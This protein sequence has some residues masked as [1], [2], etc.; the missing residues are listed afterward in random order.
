M[1]RPA[2]RLAL[3]LTLLGAPLGAQGRARNEAPP[4]VLHQLDAAAQGLARRV[5]PAIVQVVVTALASGDSPHQG[6]RS[7]GSG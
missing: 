2:V 1:T 3:C 7:N 6:E 4:S 5:S